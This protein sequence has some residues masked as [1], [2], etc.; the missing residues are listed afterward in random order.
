VQ[1]LRPTPDEI[2]LLEAHDELDRIEAAVAGGSTDLSALGFWLVV[3]QIKRD[4]V[5]E[6]EMADQ[7]GRIDQAAFRARVRLRVPV[8]AGTVLLAAVV[9]AGVVAIVLA[10]VWTGTLAGLALLAAGGAWALGIHSL[11]HQA[12]A[13]V[14]GIRCTAYFWGGPPP[15]RPGIKTDYA[16]YLRTDAARR[17]WFHASGAI[18][19]KL[20]PFVAVALSPLTNAP[21]WAVIAMAAYGVFQIATDVVFSTRTSDWKK[22]QRERAVAQELRRR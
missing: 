9:I 17:A 6:A 21:A 7:A 8:W 2:R 1:P 13:W 12:F 20:A 19:T 18:A 15:P 5:M 14:V 22:F 16:S 4:R 10:G 11:T 3:G